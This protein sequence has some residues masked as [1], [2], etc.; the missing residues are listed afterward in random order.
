MTAAI[1]AATPHSSR[2]RLL[3][4]AAAASLVHLLMMIPGYQDDGAFQTATWLAVLV[5]SLVVS[6]ALFLFVVPR[7]GATTGVVLGVVAV[8][9]CVVFWAGVTL[10]L[11]AAAGAV[12]WEARNGQRRTLA[13][14]ALGLAALSVVALVSIIISD[15]QAH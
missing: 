8:L 3:P 12:G 11:A 5:F 7:A 13:L 14:V 2:T 10:P 6:V 4:V 1:P 15:A 9:S